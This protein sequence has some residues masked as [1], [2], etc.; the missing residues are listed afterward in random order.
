MDLGSG[1]GS[2][3]YRRFI[4]FKQPFNITGVDYYKEGKNILI[5]NLEE[6]F[7]IKP[8]S[9]DC[10]MCF[11]TLEHIY[12]FKNVIRESHRIL[13]R[14]GIFIGCT[15]FVYRFHPDPH[16]YFR[17]SHEALLRMFE[18]EGYSHK[19]MMYVG[20]G[21]FSLAGTQWV[22]LLPNLF[23]RFTILIDIFNVFLDILVNKLT[24]SCRMRHAFY[25]VYIFK[26][27]LP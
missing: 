5:I 22:N 8:N 27:Q 11:N 9:F 13:R 2:P 16:D 20:F 18:E 1:S 17:Y 21:P 23:R 26:K 15:P 24:Q 25:Y 10:V 14:G 3:S 7:N 12:N 6:R 19:K 4:R